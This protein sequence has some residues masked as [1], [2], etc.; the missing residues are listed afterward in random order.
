MVASLYCSYFVNNIPALVFSVVLYLPK[1]FGILFEN[2]GLH[3]L[4]TFKLQ[5]VS[6]HKTQLLSR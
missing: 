2:I 6:R 5:F 1:M 4:H 3:A